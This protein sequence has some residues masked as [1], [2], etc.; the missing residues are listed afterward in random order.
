MDN[1]YNFR[2]GPADFCYEMKEK[3]TIKFW[4]IVQS[5]LVQNGLF[6]ISALFV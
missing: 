3:A 2:C 5:T 6:D 1:H 4:N